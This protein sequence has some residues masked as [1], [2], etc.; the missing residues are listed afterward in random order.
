MLT[1]AEILS[2]SGFESGLLYVAATV[3]AGA[4]VVGLEVLRGKRRG[5]PLVTMTAVGAGALP[6]PPPDRGPEQDPGR[7][8]PRRGH[9]TETRHA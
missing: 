6:T 2:L 9:T 8:G 1:L 4:S 7:A 3:F 5:K